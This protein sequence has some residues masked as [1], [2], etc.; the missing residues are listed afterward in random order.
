MNFYLFTLGVFLLSLT[1]LPA[2][3]MSHFSRNLRPFD[4][5]DNRPQLTNEYSHMWAVELEGG[6]VVANRI[7]SKFEMTWTKVGSLRGVYQFRLMSNQE[8]RNDEITQ[9]II[10]EPGVIRAV[11]EKYQRHVKKFDK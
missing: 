8:G 5:M 9:K 10:E 7:A 1:T 3:V 6:D 11:Q 4:G 2:P